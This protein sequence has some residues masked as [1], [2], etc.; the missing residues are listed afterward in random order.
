MRA[1]KANRTLTRSTFCDQ[2]APGMSLSTVDRVLQEANLKKWLAKDRP[3]LKAEHV[4]KR[5]R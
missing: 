1:A 2:Y 5:L 4:E 3:R